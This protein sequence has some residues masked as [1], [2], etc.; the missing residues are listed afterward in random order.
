MSCNCLHSK[1]YIKKN[2]PI[3]KYIYMNLMLPSHFTRYGP[4]QNASNES[5]SSKNV[6][7]ER[8][9]IGSF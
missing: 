9:N 7:I 6:D 3:K 8:G 2:D 4:Y 1:K 5:G